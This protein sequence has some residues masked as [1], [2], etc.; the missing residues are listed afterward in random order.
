MT[1]KKQKKSEHDEVEKSFQ[2]SEKIGRTEASTHA[3]APAREEEKTAPS[4][5]FTALVRGRGPKLPE[6]AFV[7]GA[8]KESGYIIDI[9]HVANEF[10]TE[11]VDLLAP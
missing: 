6:L 2:A 4:V 5:L 8:L 1:T 7:I 11:V 10:G 9:A 3:P